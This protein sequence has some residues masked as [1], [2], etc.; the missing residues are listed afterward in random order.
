M[1]SLKV[2]LLEFR[3][4]VCAKKARKVGSSSGVVEKYL[5]ICDEQTD[6]QMNRQDNNIGAYTTLAAHTLHRVVKILP[7]IQCNSDFYQYF[8]L[9]RVRNN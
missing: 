1:L 8:P 6:Q 7:T 5:V 2:I 9:Y 3:H 4:D